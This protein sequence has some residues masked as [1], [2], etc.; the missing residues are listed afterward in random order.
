MSKNIPT[1]QLENLTNQAGNS[2]GIF[3]LNHKIEKPKVTI[4]I[5]YRRNFYAAGICLEGQAELKVNLETYTISP[6]CLITK[7]PNTINQWSYMSDDFKTLTVF[8]TKE[9]ISTNNFIAVDNFNFFKS[10]ARH[11]FPVTNL[12]SDGFKSSLQLIKEKYDCPHPYRN[13]I[14]RNLINCMLYEIAPVYDQ[15]QVSNAVPTRGQML[16]GEFKK[17]VNA[18]SSTQRSVTFYADKLSISPKYLTEIVKEDTGKT[19]GE[20]I[21]EIVIL[22]AKILLQNPALTISQIADSLH[23][24]DQST[25][26]KFFKK[27][28]GFSPVAYK[29]GTES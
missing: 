5:P 27:S 20:S 7:P 11:I 15:H 16:V 8:F 19:A 23:F 13:E 21:A 10:V 25:F 29:Q 28:T 14:L 3:F 4:D 9:F 22:E 6:D 17:L 12:Q 18:H 2:A 1:Y 24:S 26:G